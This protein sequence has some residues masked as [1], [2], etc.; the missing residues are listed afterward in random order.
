MKTKEEITLIVN[1]ILEKA[2]P[3][4]LIALGCPKNEYK[5]EAE[6]IA[7]ILIKSKALLCSS[8]IVYDVLLEMFNKEF[9]FEECKDIS[10]KINQAL[11]C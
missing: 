10:E 9:T 2:D 7:D 5:I 6:K 11:S 4:G 3:M 1:G 8:S